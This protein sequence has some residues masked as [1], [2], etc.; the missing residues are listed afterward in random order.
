MFLIYA[1]QERVKCWTVVN[2]VVTV[3]IP[4]NV[5]L[6]WKH[7]S[8]C[9]STGEHG[10][11]YKKVHIKVDFKYQ[12]FGWLSKI[13]F[14][15]YILCSVAHGIVYTRYSYLPAKHIWILLKLKWKYWCLCAF[16]QL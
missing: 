2:T 12:N 4:W 15:N 3:L 14:L 5:L 8:C 1:A 9:K 13:M 16:I 6:K 7:V 10:V 11:S